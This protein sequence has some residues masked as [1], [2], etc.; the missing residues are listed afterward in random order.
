MKFDFNNNE[1]YI[2]VRKEIL[3]QDKP[4]CFV[5]IFRRLDAKTPEEKRLTT[6][7]LDELYK[8]GLIDQNKVDNVE[9]DEPLYAFYTDNCPRKKGRRL[10]NKR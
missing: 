6:E 3:N 7:T 8:E 9:S 1:L 4:F 2:E 5:D 10:I